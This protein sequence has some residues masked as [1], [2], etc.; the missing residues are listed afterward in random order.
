M[1]KKSEN[2]ADPTW[3]LLNEHAMEFQHCGSIKEVLNTLKDPE[4]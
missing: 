4:N 3:K 2:Q 1:T